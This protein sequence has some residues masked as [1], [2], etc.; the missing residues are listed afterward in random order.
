VVPP[1]LGSAVR[2]GR[3]VFVDGQEGWFSPGSVDGRTDWCPSHG[4]ENTECLTGSVKGSPP[5]LLSFLFRGSPHCS[6][7][8]FFFS[9]FYLGFKGT[10][11][12][13]DRSDGC[14]MGGGSGW[15]RGTG[16]RAGDVG[17]SVVGWAG[18]RKAFSATGLVMYT[19]S[20]PSGTTCARP[21]IRG[22]RGRAGHCRRGGERRG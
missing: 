15:V 9:L 7:I 14:S 6:F 8:F 19:A 17:M 13:R 4:F 22:V 1:P 10:S 3:R 2:S 11:G 18:L 20:K 5:D 21:C 16:P 12:G